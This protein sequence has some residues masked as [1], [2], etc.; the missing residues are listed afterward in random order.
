MNIAGDDIIQISN[1]MSENYEFVRNSILPCLL[2][3]ES[4]SSSAVY[5]H[6]MFEIG[7]T[8]RLEP[9]ENYGTITLSTLGFVSASADAGFNAVNSQV[10]AVLYYLSA[11][12][13]LAEADDPRFI[14]GRCARVLV[15]G[16]PAGIFG[17]I[18]PAVLENWGIEVP[19]TGAEIDLDMLEVGS[20]MASG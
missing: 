18:H 13:T 7:K 20:R 9:S 8:A 14:P 10:A 3:A 1:P 11:E 4:V 5:P 19:C 17:E 2:Q 15:G 6:N 16:K 12:Y